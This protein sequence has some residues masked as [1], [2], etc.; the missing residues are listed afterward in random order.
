[1]SQNDFDERP[2]DSEGRPQGPRFRGLLGWLLIGALAVLV[3]WAIGRGW[4]SEH[5]LSREQL[6]QL[7]A[8]PDAAKEFCFRGDVLYGKINTK[9]GREYESQYG[10]GTD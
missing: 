2:G 5:E 1:M 9:A 6:E 10:P 4:Y 3:F 7:L 8:N